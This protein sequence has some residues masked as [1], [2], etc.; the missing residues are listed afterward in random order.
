MPRIRVQPSGLTLLCD[1]GESIFERFYRADDLLARRTEGS[2][3]GL[4]IARRIVIAHAGKLTVRSQVGVG[5][6]FS[7][8][9]PGAIPLPV[10]PATS[11]SHA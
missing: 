8:Y 7:I 10:S 6:T 2:G 11:E 4:S 1:D 9:L 5:S 3:L